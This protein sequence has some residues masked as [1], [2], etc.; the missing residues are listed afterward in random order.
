MWFV[1]ALYNAENRKIYVGQTS[2]IDRRL[3]EHN[4]KRGNH[5]TSKTSGV[6]ILTYKEVVANRKEAL[7]REKQLKSSRGR[8]FIKQHIPR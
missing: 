5:F 4:K 7:K 2:D 3:I 6:W 1:Y 8:E